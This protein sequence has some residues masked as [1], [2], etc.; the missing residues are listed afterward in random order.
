VFLW[1]GP[2]ET[3]AVV[4]I[5][6]MDLGWLPTCVSMSA[7]LLLIPLQSVL[8]KLIGSIRRQTVVHTDKRVHIV[9]EV[10]RCSYVCCVLFIRL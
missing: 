4:V 10:G 6:W 3:G 8:A 2:L 5:L 1:A 7:F 9:N